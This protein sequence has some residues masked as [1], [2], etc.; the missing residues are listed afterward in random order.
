MSRTE[1]FMNADLEFDDANAADEEQHPSHSQ[2]WFLHKTTLTS[3]TNYNHTLTV[4]L[5]RL[6]RNTIEIDSPPS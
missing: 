1:T 6:I 3:E 4:K 5:P 2:T